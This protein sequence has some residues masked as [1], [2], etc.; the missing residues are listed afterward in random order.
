MKKK[1]PSLK[2]RNHFFNIYRTVLSRILNLFVQEL[3]KSVNDH[4]DDGI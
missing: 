3:L 4:Y 2:D 1:I